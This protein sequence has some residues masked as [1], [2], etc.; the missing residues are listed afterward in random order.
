MHTGKRSNLVNESATILEMDV[1]ARQRVCISHAVDIGA[2][3][4]GEERTGVGEGNMLTLGS[5]KEDN[6]S[7]RRQM[8][9]MAYRKH[10]SYTVLMSSLASDED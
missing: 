6:S 5:V 1:V 4:F 8:G 2:A 3:L 7:Q 9:Q 10:S